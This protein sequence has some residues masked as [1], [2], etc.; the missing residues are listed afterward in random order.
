MTLFIGW[1]RSLVHSIG[2]P[3]PE[4]PSFDCSGLRGPASRQALSVIHSRGG[5]GKVQESDNKHVLDPLHPPL[6]S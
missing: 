2:L 4:T 3:A 6:D 5:L 1:C